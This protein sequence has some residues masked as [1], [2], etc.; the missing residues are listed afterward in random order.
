MQQGGSLKNYKNKE[1]LYNRYWKEKLPMSIMAKLCGVHWTVIKYWMKKLDVKIRSKSEAGKLYYSRHPHNAQGK[2]KSKEIRE[3]LS[4]SMKALRK[5]K[6]YPLRGK[7]LHHWKGGR[8]KTGD[9]YLRV[10][11]PGHPQADKWGY[12]LEH[13]LIAEQALGRPLKRSEVVHHVNGDK[14]DNRPKNLLICLAKYH[15]GLHHKMAALYMQEH[16]G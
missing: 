15:Q 13:R 14:L 9:R 1:W 2:P 12:V 16:F 10:L 4:A 11:V 7:Q 6:P 5:E 8:I 3:K